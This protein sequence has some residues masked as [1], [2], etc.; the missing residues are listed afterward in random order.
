MIKYKYKNKKETGEDAIIVKTGH[1]VEFTMSNM[2]ANEKYLQIEMEKITDVLKQMEVMD[3]FKES[4]KFTPEQN[5]ATVMYR[6]AEVEKNSLEE[7][8]NNPDLTEK[9]I[10]EIKSTIDHRN[11]VMSNVLHFNPFIQDITGE[12]ADIIIEEVKAQLEIKAYKDK[13]NEITAV[14]VISE[15]EKIEI[16]KQLCKTI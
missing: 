8:L 4:P 15:L 9:E 16:K 5:N 11:A 14:L 13:L 1:S 6:S 7:S 12:I 10:I 2:E 3:I